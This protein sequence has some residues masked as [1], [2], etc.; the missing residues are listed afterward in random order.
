MS[1]S[2]QAVDVIHG[3]PAAGI[4]VRVQR[5]TSD[6]GIELDD[7]LTVEHAETDGMGY[8]RADAGQRLGR[9]PYQLIFDSNAYFATLGLRTAYKEV[10]VVVRLIGESD[11]CQLQVRLAPYYYSMYFAHRD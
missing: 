11:F 9:G 3:R 8:V 5:K 2:A 7:W 10:S 4:R 1:I 6:L